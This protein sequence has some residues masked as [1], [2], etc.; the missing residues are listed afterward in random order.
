MQEGKSSRKE[1]SKKG[2]LNAA[3]ALL[4]DKGSRLSIELNAKKKEY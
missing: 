1:K 4:E 2:S 3:T